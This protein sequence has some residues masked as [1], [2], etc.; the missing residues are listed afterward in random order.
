MV[1]HYVDET[2]EELRQSSN[3]TYNRLIARLNT[4]VPR[5]YGYGACSDALE[6]QV[7]LQDAV[8][9]QDWKTAREI[10]QQLAAQ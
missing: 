5:Q 6:L 8:N 7:R 10:T 2:D 3:R 4:E 1:R 9:A